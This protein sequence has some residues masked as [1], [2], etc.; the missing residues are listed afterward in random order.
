MDWCFGEWI[1]EAEPYTDQGQLY[2]FPMF[3]KACQGRSPM[4]PC[5]CKLGIIKDVYDF[6]Q[7]ICRIRDKLPQRYSKYAVPYGWWEGQF[8]AKN[9]MIES[10]LLND[11]VEN[12]PIR[13]QYIL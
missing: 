5:G 7:N 10:L 11:R 2:V 3:C 9:M 6:C 1:L 12:S 4:S 13:Y 8:Y